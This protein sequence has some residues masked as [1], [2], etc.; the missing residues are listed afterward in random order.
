MSAVKMKTRPQ[1]FLIAFAILSL[2]SCVSQVQPDREVGVADMIHE[3]SLQGVITVEDAW[4]RAS[5]AIESNDR[6]ADGKRVRIVARMRYR[7]KIIEL[8]PYKFDEHQNMEK[9]E[10][11]CLIGERYKNEF[12][13]FFH[14]DKKDVKQITVKR[15]SSRYSIDLKSV[16][17]KDRNIILAIIDGYLYYDFDHSNTILSGVLAENKKIELYVPLSGVR[18]IDILGKDCEFR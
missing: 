16:Y 10:F 7:N 12:P 8:F 9:Y 5:K 4:A 1:P 6:G 17:I 11:D 14:F 2:S 13:I 3:T 18:I 15:L